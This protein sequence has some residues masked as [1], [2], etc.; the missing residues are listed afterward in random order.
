M[1]LRRSAFNGQDL[2]PLM[3][4][5]PANMNRFCYR[6]AKPANLLLS[7]WGGVFTGLK[8]S[9]LSGP[10]SRHCTRAS[11]LLLCVR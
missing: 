7:L 11:R 1:T 9:R 4:H 3:I 6:C 2:R 5:G 10:A 8:G